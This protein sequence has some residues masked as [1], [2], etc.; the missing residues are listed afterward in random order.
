MNPAPHWDATVVGLIEKARA[1]E[2]A[3]FEALAVRYDME[4]RLAGNLAA[5]VAIRWCAEA[6]RETLGGA[7]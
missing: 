5:S 7:S 4:A 1:D 2:R 3:R 6:L